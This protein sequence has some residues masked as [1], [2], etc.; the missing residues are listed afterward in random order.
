MA[1]N[2]NIPYMLQIQGFHVGLYLYTK[3]FT[4]REPQILT[5]HLRPH[6]SWCSN[7]SW[8]WYFCVSSVSLSGGLVKRSVSSSL[9][10]PLFLCPQEAQ[11]IWSGTQNKHLAKHEIARILLVEQSLALGHYKPCS[12]LFITTRWSKGGGESHIGIIDKDPHNYNQ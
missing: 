6:C 9:L 11:S 2:V 10:F 3:L 7:K 4:S 8:S 1:R 5:M 12:S